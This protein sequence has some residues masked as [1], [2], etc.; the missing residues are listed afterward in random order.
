MPLDY[1]VEDIAENADELYGKKINPVPMPPVDIGIDT[2]NKLIWDLDAVQ[3]S[4]VDTASINSLT[5]VSQ[6]RDEL[7]T[8]IDNM[9]EDTTLA[10]ALEIYVED[11]TEKNENGRIVW[12]ESED[13]NIAKYVNFLLDSLNVDKN[14]YRWVFC[15]C[16]YGDVYLRL[17]RESDV[18]DPIFKKRK[19]ALNESAND[20]LKEAI[21]VSIPNS[22]EKFAFYTEMVQNP[23]K[24]FELIKFGKTAGYIEAPIGY[25]SSMYSAEASKNTMFLNSFLT[26]R[27]QER[28]IKIYPATEFVHASL[29]DDIT[30][31]PEEVSIILDAPEEDEKYYDEYDEYGRKRTD[32]TVREKTSTSSDSAGV[33]ASASVSYNVKRGQ[34]VLYDVFKTWRQLSLLENSVLLNRLTKSSVTRVIG[35][36]VGDMPKEKVRDT[37]YRFKQE[38]EQKSAIATAQGMSEYTNPGAYENS[39]YV[40]IYG[41][42]GTITTT[43]I[44]GDTDT[45]VNGLSDL[46][47]FKTKMYSGLKIP[48][49]YLGDT[50]DATGFNG[51]TALSIV[52]SRYAKTVMR[53]Q[54]VM[55]QCITDLINLI[56]FDRQFYSY[57]NKFDLKMTAPTTQEQL[58]RQEQKSSQ[59]Q[60]IRDIM[61]LT[62]SI[63][64]PVRKLKILKS[65]LAGLSMDNDVISIIQDEIE[66]LEA[67]IEQ[68]EGNDFDDDEQMDLDVDVHG[69]GGGGRSFNAGFEERNPIA[70]LASESGGEE[71]AS[72]GGA[73]ANEP[74]GGEL[75]NMADL[76][77]DFT[78]NTGA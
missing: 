28:D 31:A 14:I 58:D 34:S 13:A 10:A 64:D 45:N 59:V 29:E 78:D 7:Y 66:E 37:L 35:L 5:S 50:D 63:E 23:A 41:D 40:P 22:N 2:D 38:V 32:K 18:E 30:R 21:K 51:G 42:K 3:S 16:K 72:T 43:L 65:L 9:C 74:A 27:F 6:R 20:S 49:Q 60:L 56:L 62:E 1:D 39:I 67:N 77:I 55:T 68:P 54:S 24:V 53:I 33:G 48:K 61:D 75:P 47:Y 76:G 12:A 19:T 73:E 15:L 17:F 70:D 69:G 26:Y 71:E 11:V 36:Q 44:G 4:R 8:M 57:I 46:D 52:S 25:S